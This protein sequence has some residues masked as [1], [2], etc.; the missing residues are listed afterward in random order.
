MSKSKSYKKTKHIDNQLVVMSRIDFE[1]AKRVYERALTLGMDDEEVSFLLGKR[2][3]YVFD[4]LDP[5]EKNKFKTE[6]LDYLPTILR[7]SIRELIPTDRGL[8]E[9][10]KIMASKA[11]YEHKIV[12]Q[13]TEL[14]VETLQPVVWTKKLKIG[15][16]RK[17]HE[18]LHER[19]MEYY[20]NGGFKLPISSLK[21]FLDLHK[22]HDQSSFTPSDLQKSL[23]TLM[24]AKGRLQILKRVSI[25]VRYY[26]IENTG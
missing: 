22:S 13:F 25:N 6:Q 21:L 23:S 2:N 5:T 20:E 19:I 8:H 7:T 12:Y 4:I 24:T 16:I 26:Y 1:I 3:K 9:E 14:D 10:I 18:A 17:V 15:S 11:V